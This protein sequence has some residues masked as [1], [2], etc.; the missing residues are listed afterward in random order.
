M[1]HKK[2]RVFFALVAIF[3]GL[4]AHAQI[5]Q[6]GKKTD[7]PKSSFETMPPD[8]DAL[9]YNTA[10]DL[11]THS[12]GFAA[13]GVIGTWDIENRIGSLGLRAV[14]DLKFNLYSAM[15]RGMIPV[16]KISVSAPNMSPETVT[17]SDRWANFVMRD[18][19]SGKPLGYLCGKTTFK[20]DDKLVCRLD[21]PDARNDGREGGNWKDRVGFAVYDASEKQ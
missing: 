13:H 8:R 21:D 17:V 4:N 9:D 10:L 1:K 16:G 15:T 2:S 18:T 14:P 5:G 6:D 7:P 12:E 11:W 19:F 20:G 3:W